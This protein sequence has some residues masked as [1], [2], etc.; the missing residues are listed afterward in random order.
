[1]NECPGAFDFLFKPSRYKVAYG[2]RGGA[3][4]WNFARALLVLGTR[5]PL[6]I[7]CARE[8]QESISES[9]HRLLSDQIGLL[10]LTPF[11]T[12]E[13]ARIYGRNGTEFTFAGL[14][15]NVAN[16]K[17]A[18]AMDVCW[19]E[20]AQS[21]SK[22]SWR[23]LIPT[24][25]KEGSEIWVSFNPDFEDDP[26]YRMFLRNPPPDAVI[27]K[28]T[29]RDNPWFPD[30]LKREMEHM[31][32]TDPD[33]YEHV[34]EGS[35][36][37][38]LQSAIYANEL[39]AVERE[40]RIC[41]V[42][43]DH[44]RPVDCYWDLGYG[45]MTAIWMAQSM[46]FQYRLIDYIEDCAKPL[47]WYLQQMQARGYIFGTDWLP[48]DIGMHAKQ[49]G[50]GRSIEELLRLAGRKVRIVPRLT[51]ADGIAAARTVFPLCWF[52]R[53]RCE[54]G[55][56]RLRHY[57]YGEIKTMQHHTREPLHD[58]ASHGSDAFRAFAICAKPPRPP[59][60]KP[61]VQRREPSE[62]VS[63]WT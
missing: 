30:V 37:S 61:V 50:S 54:K 42:P 52:D 32:R 21:V 44:S 7:L 20:E 13:K 58:D 59:A 14:L 29:Y 27:R 8:T 40:D 3:K 16:I 38:L 35:C 57:R 12:V 53:E 48:W 10:E 60:P 17:S 1:M 33:E 47:Q 23:V 6:R 9:V 46:P 43:Y 18:E 15:H 49:L 19:V 36:I 55:L 2:G 24:I 4:S 63:A 28:V 22:E 56:R 45:D 25:R 5:R 51:V 62:Y 31:R 39:R 41:S 26:T 34:W 11:Y